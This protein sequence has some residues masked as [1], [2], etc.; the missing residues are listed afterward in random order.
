MSDKTIS[1]LRGDD[2]DHIISQLK[3][4]RDESQKAH[5]TSQKELDQL[6]ARYGILET[7]LAETIINLKLEKVVVSE[8]KKELSAIEAKTLH[9]QDKISFIFKPEEE[10]AH[11]RNFSAEEEGDSSIDQVYYNR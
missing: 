6:R 4:E 7:K 8:L 11:L 2:Q 9:N 10:N 3:A 1:F 5:F